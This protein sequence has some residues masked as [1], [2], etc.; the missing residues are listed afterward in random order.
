MVIKE[1]I[2]LVE[3]VQ[4]E[5][6]NE[7]GRD[8]QSYKNHVNRIIILCLYLNPELNDEQVKKVII[9]AYFLMI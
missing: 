2:V 5:Y 7:L 4:N 6:R 1:N 3:S 8:Y 9:A